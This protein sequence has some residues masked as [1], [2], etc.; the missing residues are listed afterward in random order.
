GLMEGPQSDERYNAAYLIDHHAY[1][2]AYKLTQE[3][4]GGYTPYRH[5]HFRRHR[6]QN[7]ASLICL[8]AVIEQL[9]ECDGKDKLHQTF[10][11]SCNDL[12]NDMILCV[13]AHFTAEP[14]C[15]AVQPWVAHTKMVVIA[16]SS[17][18]FPSR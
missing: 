16:T 7:I 12:K 14:T 1:P 8:D 2:L 4:T 9:G 10:I 13:P 15:S 5:S 18:R 11:D 6:G 3:K 17:P